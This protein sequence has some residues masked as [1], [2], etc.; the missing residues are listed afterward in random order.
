MK[1]NKPPC[2]ISKIHIKG[3]KSIKNVELSLKPGINIIIG[4][5][6]SGK[7]NFLEAIEYCISGSYIDFVELED[8]NNVYFYSEVIT[9]ERKIEQEINGFFVF[10]DESD[11]GF[12][13]QTEV[14]FDDELVLKTNATKYP[15]G[16]EN[17]DIVGDWDEIWDDMKMNAHFT[18]N[19][20]SIAMFD[21]PLKLKFMPETDWGTDY[22][23][24]IVNEGMFDFKINFFVLRY[25]TNL[26]KFTSDRKEI[27]N[28]IVF[29]KIA[30]ASLNKLTP[31]TNISFDKE[32]VD[33]KINAEEKAI[34]LT[35]VVPFF[36]IGDDK[37]T[38]RQLSEG[39]RRLV[40]LAIEISHFMQFNDFLVLE[41]PELHLHISQLNTLLGFLK[42]AGQT[43]QIIISTY[44][45]EVLKIIEWT[46]L[47]R[48][49]VCKFDKEKGTIL[50]KLTSEQAKDLGEILKNMDSIQR[51]YWIYK[52]IEHYILNADNLN[53]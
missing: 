36:H 28:S 51:E 32:I 3:H 52:N 40:A 21:K 45:P 17:D 44:S 16:I 41:E 38:W 30:L 6:G 35:N 22:R 50:K 31:V 11:I 39:Q 49:I 19:K 25:S 26:E 15:N 14:F 12:R 48:I 4:E 27:L 43:F 33:I 24:C 9:P 10:N 47:D 8:K 2:Y 42:R 1:E 20:Y 46:E 7:S 34:Q 37:Y 5:N 29:D 53:N 13:E 18:T 23:I